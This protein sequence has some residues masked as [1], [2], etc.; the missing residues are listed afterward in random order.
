MTVPAAPTISAVHAGDTALTVVWT[1]PSAVTGITNYDVRYILT[2]ADETVDANWTLKENV[3]TDG[4]Q[5]LYIIAGLSNDVSYDVQVRVKTD[6]NGAWSSTTEGEAEDRPPTICPAQAT[7]PINV[8]LGGNLSTYFDR[9]R[10]SFQVTT[11]AAFHHRLTG[12]A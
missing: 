8:P 6:T 10:Y 9:D 1:D 11:A 4:D 2:S 5:L 12:L 7:I 3:W